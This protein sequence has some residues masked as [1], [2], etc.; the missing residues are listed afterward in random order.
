MGQLSNQI[1]KDF[2]WFVNLW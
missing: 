2:L 1:L